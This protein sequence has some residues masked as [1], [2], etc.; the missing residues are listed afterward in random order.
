MLTE[1]SETLDL[2]DPRPSLKDQGFN[3]LEQLQMNLDVAIKALPS[4]K[5][6]CKV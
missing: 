1:V 2:H 5:P 4:A 3:V 6:G